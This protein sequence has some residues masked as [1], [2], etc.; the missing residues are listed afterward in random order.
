MLLNLHVWVGEFACADCLPFP[1][2]HLLGGARGTKKRGKKEGRQK[3]EKKKRKTE[4]VQKW[5][6]KNMLHYPCGEKM[7]VLP[8][9]KS[10]MEGLPDDPS[11]FCHI[12][13]T[14]WCKIRTAPFCPLLP[15]LNAQKKELIGNFPPWRN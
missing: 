2:D 3:W 5:E 4:R 8:M 13:L 6:K 14:T 11:S 15:T 1:R 7:E 12:M 10:Q 9:R